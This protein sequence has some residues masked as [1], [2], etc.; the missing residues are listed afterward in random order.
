MNTMIAFRRISTPITPITNSTAEKKIAS[1]NMARLP[2]LLAK[3]HCA[4]HCGEE[5]NARHLERQQVSV[6]QR[7]SDRRDH[8]GLLHLLGDDASRQRER[9]GRLGASEREDL[10][11]NS[12]ANRAGRNL[13]A[14]PAHVVADSR[15][16]VEQHDDEQE[17]DH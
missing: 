9:H 16:E 11:E 4:N 8:A 5:Q 3:Y 2:S 13:P 17:H 1:A 6:E 12:D 15:P 7:S 14:K 10:S